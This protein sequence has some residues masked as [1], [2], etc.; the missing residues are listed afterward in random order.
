MRVNFM[1]VMAR[2]PPNTSTRMLHSRIPGF[3]WYITMEV[4][5]SSIS[6]RMVM[7]AGCLCYLSRS[8]WL[9][10]SWLRGSTW[11]SENVFAQ[12]LPK[13]WSWN[14]VTQL[15]IYRR[16]RKTWHATKICFIT[17]SKNRRRSTWHHRKLPHVTAMEKA[18]KEANEVVKEVT[19]EG[20]RIA[21]QE[22]QTTSSNGVP[23]FTRL[24]R[25]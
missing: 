22:E 9:V 4:Y 24:D 3:V 13:I 23:N 19:K 15:T 17:S 10:C 14:W 25:T 1:K 5:R 8:V 20:H 18:K 6:T 12:H 11:S 16:Q 21:H 7:V 2:L